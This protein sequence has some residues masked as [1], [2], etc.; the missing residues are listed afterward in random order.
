MFRSCF[1]FCSPKNR[2]MQILSINN[3]TER[4]KKLFFGEMIR[5]RASNLRWLLKEVE[6]IE[7]K[8]NEITNFC[9]CLDK[10]W[11][12]QLRLFFFI[13][14]IIKLFCNLYNVQFLYIYNL[15]AII[16]LDRRSCTVCRYFMPNI[17]S[18]IEFKLKIKTRK[19][20]RDSTH[21]KIFRKR[22]RL[23]VLFLFLSKSFSLTIWEEKK[24]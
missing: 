4:K 5:S 12:I 18:V 17:L 8:R 6:R 9:C 7:R 24:N 15:N 11:S 13:T 10:K 2:V 14:I 20:R 3:K 22:I 21:K 16:E 1:F 19:R 23:Q